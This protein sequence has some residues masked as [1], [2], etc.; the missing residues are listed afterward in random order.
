LIY[1]IPV[2]IQNAKPGDGELLTEIE[3]I[4]ILRKLLFDQLVNYDLA[5]AVV[6]WLQV[7]SKSFLEVKRILQLMGGKPVRHRGGRNCRKTFY[8]DG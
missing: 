1:W 3:G 7:G 4:E 5:V 2:H 6:D 8:H